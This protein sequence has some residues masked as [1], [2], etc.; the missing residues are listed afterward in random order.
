MPIERL[1][2]FNKVDNFTLSMQNFIVNIVNFIHVV[3]STIQCMLVCRLQAQMDNQAKPFFHN[4]ATHKESTE[5]PEYLTFREVFVKNCQN[6][7]Q[8][9]GFTGSHKPKAGLAGFLLVWFT[10]S[11]TRLETNTLVVFLG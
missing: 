4:I 11:Y 1:V 6:W 3:Y 5:H 8:M 7:P 10:L 9:I 2:I